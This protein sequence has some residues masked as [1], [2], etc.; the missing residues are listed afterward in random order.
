MVCLCTMQGRILQLLSW[1]AGR[2]RGPEYFLVTIIFHRGLYD[3]P[4][5][6]QLLFK[7]GQYQYLKGRGRRFCA[8]HPNPSGSAHEHVLN[9]SMFLAVF[10]VS[11][12][13]LVDTC[14]YMFFEIVCRLYH[15]CY[16]IA[17]SLYAIQILSIF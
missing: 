16:V 17:I 4:P 7:V 15:L 13:C 10:I 6:V 1:R 3:S 9:T 14:I 5:R 2:R 8:P 11:I 12:Y